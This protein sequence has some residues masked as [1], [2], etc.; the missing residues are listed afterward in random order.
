MSDSIDPTH[1]LTKNQLIMTNSKTTKWSKL[2]AA[3]SQVLCVLLVNGH[4]DEMLSSY[5]YRTNNTKLISFIEFFFGKD[6]C[7]NSY[8]WE[9]ARPKYSKNLIEDKY[10]HNLIEDKYSKNL[11]EDKYTKDSN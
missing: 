8:D 5:S 7:K 4:E 2:K 6:H 10:S 1:L 9:L 11:I 3:M